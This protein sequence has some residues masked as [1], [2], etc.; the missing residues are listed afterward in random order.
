MERGKKDEKGNLFL[1]DKKWMNDLKNKY[2]YD[3]LCNSIIS[4]EKIKNIINKLEKT[5]NAKHHILID[6]IK[7]FN[8]DIFYDICNASVKENVNN[9]GLEYQNFYLNNEK[10]N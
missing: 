9:Y 3:K 7:E 10:I 2:S 8:W 5:E 4:I 6:I 1:V